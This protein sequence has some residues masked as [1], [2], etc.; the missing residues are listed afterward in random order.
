MWEKLVTGCPVS[1]SPNSSWNLTQPKTKKKCTSHKSKCVWA[2]HCPTQYTS[3]IK[4]AREKDQGFWNRYQ[5]TM[6]EL[7]D[8]AIYSSVM[9]SPLVYPSYHKKHLVMSF[10]LRTTD[11][12]GVWWFVMTTHT[13]LIITFWNFSWYLT[14]FMLHVIFIWIALLFMHSRY[15]YHII[16]YVFNID[17][18]NLC[19]IRYGTTNSIPR[20]QWKTDDQNMRHFQSIP[21]PT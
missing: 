10:R 12:V 1:I 17:Y 8:L 6:L 15:P 4:P 21:R 9:L 3:S 11:A 7:I 5:N 16:L 18:W 19:T 2:C 13:R 20:N 14:F